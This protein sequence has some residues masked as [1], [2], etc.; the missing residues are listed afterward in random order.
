MTDSDNQFVAL[1]PYRVF[2]HAEPGHSVHDAA[3]TTVE[4][5]L[6]G[7]LFNDTPVYR[8]SGDTPEAM[9]GR[10]MEQRGHK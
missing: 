10:Y 4:L 7:F 8:K 3:K 1:D 6:R 5:G 2:Y 9:I